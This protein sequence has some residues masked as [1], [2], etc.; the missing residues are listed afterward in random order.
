MIQEDKIYN[1]VVKPVVFGDKLSPQVPGVGVGEPFPSLGTAFYESYAKPLWIQLDTLAPGDVFVV[2]T[3]SSIYYVVLVG[4]RVGLLYG[5]SFGDDPCEVVLHGG[6]DL[7]TAQPEWG[8]LQ[9][10]VPFLFAP[11]R[12]PSDATKTSPIEAIYLQK[13]ASRAGYVAT[14]S[15]PKAIGGSLAVKP[16]VVGL[17]PLGTPIKGVVKPSLV[18]TVAKKPISA[19]IGISPSAQNRTGGIR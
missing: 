19:P 3:L 11:L 5:K 2:K 8:K 4:I 1:P 12:A 13:S 14:A 9:V 6:Y 16:G 17:K 15:L 10:G 18:Q 7:D